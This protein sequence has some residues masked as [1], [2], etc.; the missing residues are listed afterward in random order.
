MALVGLFVLLDWGG[1]GRVFW[2]FGEVFFGFGGFI[3]FFTSQT[4]LVQPFNIGKHSSNI[5]TKHLRERRKYFC[6]VFLG[7]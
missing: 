1:E 3:L 2:F 5:P 4:V 7:P 6:T